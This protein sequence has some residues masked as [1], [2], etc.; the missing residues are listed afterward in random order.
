MAGIAVPITIGQKPLNVLQKKTELPTLNYASRLPILV[1]TLSQRWQ[2]GM[3][4]CI[5]E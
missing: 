2:S 4:P 5:A 1:S 3:R